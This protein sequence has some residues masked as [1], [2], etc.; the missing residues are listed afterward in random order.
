M[1]LREAGAE[2]TSVGM[3]LEPVSGK[4]GL[5]ELVALFA[6]HHARQR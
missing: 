6:E 1:R 3:S 4:N 5:R 2:V